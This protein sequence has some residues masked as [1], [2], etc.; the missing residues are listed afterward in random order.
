MLKLTLHQLRCFRDEVPV[1]LPLE[2]S[3]SSREAFLCVGVNGA[4]K[5]TLLRALM[6]LCPYEGRLL[7]NDQPLPHFQAQA[8]HMSVRGGL[9]GDLTVLQH[10]HFWM[11]FWPATK[12]MLT[13]H[14]E[15]LHLT[16]FKNRLVRTLSSGER[17]RLK[18]FP[19]LLQR[20]PLWLLDEPFTHLDEEGRLIFESLMDKHL[21]EGGMA[22]LT[23]PSQ[24]KGG[25]L[26]FT[27][28][29]RDLLR[30]AS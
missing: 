6:G 19:L 25:L 22:L 8:A 21:L 15:R 10:V 12:E 28:W 29:H 24:T 9:R 16:P 14:L 4:G 11:L 26:Q 23:K 5:T 20:K 18:F 1:F 2:L 27:S 7:W 17:Q 30:V 13:E 3:I